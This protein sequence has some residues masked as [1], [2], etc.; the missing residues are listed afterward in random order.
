[1]ANC[2]DY[3]AWRGD[4]SFSKSEFNEIDGMIIS[5]IAYLPF[6][7]VGQKK[8]LTLSELCEKLLEIPDLPKYLVR[9][10]DMDLILAISESSRFSKLLLVEYESVTETESETQFAAITV[11]IA[12]GVSYVAF[13]GTDDSLV[14]WKEDFNM[15]FT[16]PVPAQELAALYIDRIARRVRGKF[17][18]G[19][20]SK[21]GNLAVYASAFCKS[22]IHNRFLRI[23]NFDGPGF[24][25][26]VLESPEYLQIRDKIRTYVP[27]SSV[28]GLLLFREG[29]YITVDSS[30]TGLLQHDTY[31]WLCE[32]DKF[33]YLET[34]TG[35][36]KVIDTTLKDWIL[37]LAPENRELLIDALYELLSET[38]A[39]TLSELSENWLS[40]TATVLRSFGK[41]DEQTRKV[42]NEAIRALIRGAS[43]TIS[44]ELQA[45]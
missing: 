21:G 41:L 20:H 32:K 19:G 24:L 18:V 30:Y 14:G 22:R 23:E 25:P 39:K 43:R 36:S 8:A 27:K 12:P 26:K 4:L 33:V 10:T 38:K 9:K 17:I 45:K 44:K 7:L 31:S 35:T 6:E 2:F 5:R 13:R 11:R 16:F 37:E 29:S 28:V 40:N 15:S 1:M 3:L 34:V 42:L